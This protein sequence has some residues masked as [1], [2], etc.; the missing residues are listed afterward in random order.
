M[1]LLSVPS[2][3]LYSL[4]IAAFLIYVPYTVV[5]LERIKLA[6]SMDSSME[7]LGRPRFYSDQ[8]PEF[9]QR[10]NWAHQNSFESFILY[11]PAAVMAYVT[12]QESTAALLAVVAYLVARLFFSVFYILNVPPL[13]S[14]M[15]GIGSLSIFSLYFMSC[16]TIWL[17]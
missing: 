1:S 16:K 9:A 7:V 10:A 5:A 13:R 3:F 2:I 11:A 14:L 4:P 17:Q 8:L 12:S 15:F 6:Q